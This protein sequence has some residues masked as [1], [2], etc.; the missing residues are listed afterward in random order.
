MA[1]I[2][3]VGH[4]LTPDYSTLFVVH[5]EVL[6]EIMQRPDLPDVDKRFADGVVGRLIA[7]DDEYRTSN[8][9]PRR[10]FHGRFTDVAEQE[11]TFQ[12]EPDVDGGLPVPPWMLL[13][14]DRYDPLGDPVVQIPACP[15]FKRKLQLYSSTSPPSARLLPEREDLEDGANPRL[16][17]K[18]FYGLQVYGGAIILVGLLCFTI[19]ALFS[20][21]KNYKSTQAQRGWTMSWFI[22]GI[23]AG[24]AIPLG[25]SGLDSLLR[26]LTINIDDLQE[27]LPQYSILIRRFQLLYVGPTIGGLVVVAQMINAYGNCI[28]LE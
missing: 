1:G 17:L 24:Y 7:A 8:Y 20:Q 3:L 27:R 13:P 15:L 23:L 28:K 18:D 11:V 19:I 14:R 9:Q 22:S 25:R 16:G 6:E 21:M 26:Y 5:N 2:N 12:V 10:L 4:L